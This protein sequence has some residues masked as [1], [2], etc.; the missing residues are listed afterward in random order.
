MKWLLRRI[1][2]CIVAVLI[3][4]LSLLALILGVSCVLTLQ[5]QQEGNMAILFLLIAGLGGFLAYKCWPGPD[6]HT[7]HLKDTL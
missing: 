3:G 7:I 4:L 5:G 1:L 2:R 6:R